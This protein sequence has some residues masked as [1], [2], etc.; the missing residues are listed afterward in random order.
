MGS[1][2]MSIG[3]AEAVVVIDLSVSNR[4]C[5]NCDEWR[6]ASHQMGSCMEN[7]VWNFDDGTFNRQTRYEDYCTWGWKGLDSERVGVASG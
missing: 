7:T 5:G 6:Y 2:K 4:C 3:D 1:Y